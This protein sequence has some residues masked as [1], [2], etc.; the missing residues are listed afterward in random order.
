M[1]N[2][3][4]QSSWSILLLPLALIAGLVLLLGFHVGGPSEAKAMITLEPW[5]QLLVGYLAAG[6]EISAAVVIAVAVSCAIGPSF[7]E[8]LT[9]TDAHSNYLAN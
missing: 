1:N 8:L 2:E 6:A 4:A 7:Y 3:T 5:F 9:S